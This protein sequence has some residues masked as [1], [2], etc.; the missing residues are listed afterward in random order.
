M[1]NLTETTAIQLFETV[2][3]LSLITE[4]KKINL[5]KG[6]FLPKNQ[7]FAHN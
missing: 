5:L 6:N 1:L 3:C 4:I 2:I 7:F